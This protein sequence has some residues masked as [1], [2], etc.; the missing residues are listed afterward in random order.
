MP[1]PAVESKSCSCDVA[2]KH[3]LGEAC[4]EEAFRHFL[5][6]ERKRSRRSGRA[7]FVLLVRA[8]R[9]GGVGARLDPV[10]VEKL[11]ACLWLCLRATD[12]VGWFCEGRVA[13]A[14]LADVSDANIATAVCEK[15]R[16]A[17][18]AGLPADISSRLAVRAFR[19]PSRSGL[20]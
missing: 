2:L 12:Q 10:V 13:G 18:H 16:G 4:N 7:F 14:L 3:Q 19:F 6:M 20:R 8:T 9:R 17:L 11:F 5:A 1:E 15:V